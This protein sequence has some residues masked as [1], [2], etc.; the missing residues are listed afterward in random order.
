MALENTRSAPVFMEIGNTEKAKST[1]VRRGKVVTSRH[2][3][4][5]GQVDERMRYRRRL[6]SRHLYGWCDFWHSLLCRA[7][8]NSRS[9]PP[10]GALQGSKAFG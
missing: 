1:E 8:G 10:D 9:K 4:V 6:T 2:C 5:V 3:V 7:F